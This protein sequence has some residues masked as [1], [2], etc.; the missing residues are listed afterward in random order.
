VALTTDTLSQASA[1]MPGVCPR[2]WTYAT[3]DTTAAV[4][5]ANYWAYTGQKLAAGDLIDCYC[6]DGWTRIGVSAA[7][8][9]T[10]TVVNVGGEGSL[11]DIV[12][13]A[14]CTGLQTAGAVGYALSPVAGTIVSWDF[15]TTV[16]VD[17]ADAVLNLDVAGAN[18]T[19]SIT[20]A[21]SDTAVGITDSATVTAGGAVTAG[22]AIK[23]ESDGGPG[24]T[25]SGVAYIRIRPS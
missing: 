1:G 7:T 11:S 9:T 17:T 3:A 5:V 15:L 16:V 2:L 21:V 24:S 18:A 10:S 8:A 22:Q 19:G 13:Q 12:V 25:G 23:V 20:V 14:S 4:L 6:V